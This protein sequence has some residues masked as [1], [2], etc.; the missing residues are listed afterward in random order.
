MTG[1]RAPP[2]GF[3]TQKQISNSGGTKMY[4][5]HPFFIDGKYYAKINDEMIEIT[6]EVAYAMNNFRR[7]SLPKYVEVKNEQGEVIEKWL[8]EVPYSSHSDDGIDYSVETMP[9][10][11]C[12]VEEE[13]INSACCQEVQKAIGKL[14]DI[15]KIII[16]AVYFEEMPLEKVGSLL[17]V[18]Y[19]AIQKKLKVIH[20]KMKKHLVK[21]N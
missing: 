1:S 15:E 7:N 8:R 19:Q 9:D 17:G 5:E 20:A 4:I 14:N 10:P 6:K 21:K 18:S 3:E 11:L 12:D 13:A 16:R 2:S